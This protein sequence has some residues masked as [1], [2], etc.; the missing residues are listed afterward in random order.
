MATQ[1]SSEG[2]QNPAY[3]PTHRHTILNWWFVLATSTPD[4]EVDRIQNGMGLS[5]ANAGRLLTVSEAAE[6]MGRSART[7]RRLVHQRRRGSDGKEVV[8][9]GDPL[10]RQEGE[11]TDG[12]S[13]GEWIHH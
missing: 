12:N 5:F 8:K 1:P 7:P 13:V 3:R 9:I 6:R 10:P 11:H 4:T 2:G